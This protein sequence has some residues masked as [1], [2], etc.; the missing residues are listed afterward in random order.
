MDL[1]HINIDSF[2]R[3]G[4]GLYDVRC[5]LHHSYVL[6]TCRQR[7]WT[8]LTSLLLPLMWQLVDPSLRVPCPFRPLACQTLLESPPPAQEAHAPCPTSRS[9]LLTCRW[10][11]PPPL[12]PQPR[13]V[14]KTQHTMLH[15]ICSA[16]WMLVDFT[17]HSFD[18]ERAS[19]L[20][21]ASVNIYV[22]VCCIW[23]IIKCL[24]YYGK[25]ETIILVYCLEQ[26]M[27]K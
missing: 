5:I 24:F 20:L 14:L 19:F 7:Y 13:F 22:G 2:F 3:P 17:V 4:R 26:I 1:A 11:L 15:S 21:I 12:C 8:L 9:F 16:C 25:T 18:T 27:C 6:C 10:A 23:V